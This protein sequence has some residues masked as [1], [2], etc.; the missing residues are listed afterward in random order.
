[1]DSTPNRYEIRH[2]I[3]APLRVRGRPGR[4]GPSARLGPDLEETRK[5]MLKLGVGDS[6]VVP[7]GVF[8]GRDH[9]HLLALISNQA[10][11]VLGRGNYTTLAV[12][13]GVCVWRLR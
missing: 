5:V 6:F 8:P 13:A 3:P 12:E 4:S 2:D 7:L 1:M 10:G 9:E 11:Y